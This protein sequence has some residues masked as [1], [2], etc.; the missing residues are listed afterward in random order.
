MKKVIIIFVVMGLVLISTILWFLHSEVSS[1]ELLFASGIIIVLGFA[2][3]VGIGRLKSF[4]RKE[5]MEDEL[6]K[7]IMLKTSSL[8]YYLSLYFWLVIMYLS[9]KTDLESH[10]LIGV[11]I[12]GMAIIFLLSWIGVKLFGFKNE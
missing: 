8:S 12:M 6:S 10:S 9:D 1:T 4:S 11:G 7:K 3:F 2:L 5:P